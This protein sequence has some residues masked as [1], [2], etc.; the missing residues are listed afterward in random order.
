V[1]SDAAG[2]PAPQKAGMNFEDPPGSPGSSVQARFWVCWGSWWD[3]GVAAEKGALG[4]SSSAREGLGGAE[5]PW[6]WAGAEGFGPGARGW[7][8][9]VA[10]EVAELLRGECSEGPGL[11][12]RASRVPWHRV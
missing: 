8:N 6:G 1:G 7:A 11:G 2:P 10:S 5:V 9:A 4:G 12:L 3:G